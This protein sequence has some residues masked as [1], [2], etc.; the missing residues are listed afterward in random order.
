[1]SAAKMNIAAA[2]IVV[3]LTAAFVLGLLTPGVKKLKEARASAAQ[4]VERVKEKQAAL[5]NISE[6][7]ASTVELGSQ[8]QGFRHRLPRDRQFGEFLSYLSDGFRKCKIINYVVEPRPSMTI[9]EE[10]VP[11]EL[12]LAVG[13]TVLPVRIE[14]QTDFPAMVKFLD[15]LE[16][17]RRLSHVE[18][19]KLIND[20]MKPGRIKADIVVHTYFR[21]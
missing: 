2:V 21:P 16:K 7:Y 5:G 10:G 11:D 18:S 20:E 15:Y 8:L 12:K 3:V 19:L 14:F 13:T 17:N 6:L 1:M 9:V 4:E